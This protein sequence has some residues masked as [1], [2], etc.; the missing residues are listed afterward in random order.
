MNIITGSSLVLAL[1]LVAPVIQAAEKIPAAERMLFVGNSLT[2]FGNAPAIYAALSTANGRPVAAD[3]IVEGGATL[4]QRVADGS[5]QQALQERSYDTLV[6]QERG[7][8]LLCSFGPHSCIQSRAATMALASLA[9]RHGVKVVM[10]GSYQPHPATSA[11]L[12]QKETS[13][14]D[15]A[16]VTYAEVS[17]KLQHLT[18]AA[19]ALAWFAADGMH[20]GKDLALLNAIVIY[21]AVHGELPDAVELTISAPIYAENTGLQATLRAADAPAPHEDTDEGT[22]YSA[23]TIAL[24][25]GIISASERD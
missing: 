6:I 7:G 13:A 8:D 12:V 24:I 20:P 1:L 11:L 22:Q 2:Y 16:G 9:K 10:L 17:E 3:M 15:E 4:T 5:V 21:D 14:C 19:P 25:L 18:A 23:A